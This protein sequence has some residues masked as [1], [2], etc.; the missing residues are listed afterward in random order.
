MCKHSA[1]ALF[2]VPEYKKAMICFMEK[3]C[4]LDKLHAGMSYSAV[5]CKFRVNESTVYY[6]QKRKKEICQSIHEVTQ[7]N[8]KVTSIYCVIKL[9][10]RW[11]SSS[12]HGFMK[13]KQIFFVFV[14]KYS[15]KSMWWGTN[16]DLC[17]T[18]VKPFLTCCLSH[19]F[20]RRI[21]QTRGLQKNLKITC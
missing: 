16:A 3:V 2:S 14:F 20:H 8:A 10:I 13:Q 12:M 9:W 18:N 15:Y 6:N 21:L 7:R 11:K 17:S 1:E 4:V 19:M 5:D